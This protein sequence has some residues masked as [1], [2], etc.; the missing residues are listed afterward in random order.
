MSLRSLV[1]APAVLLCTLAVAVPAHAAALPA[2][3]GATDLAAADLEISAVRAAP[4]GDVNG[5]GRSDLAVARDGL[6]IVLGGTGGRLSTSPGLRVWSFTHSGGLQATFGLA[7]DGVGDINGDGLDDVLVRWAVWT[8]TP[9]LTAGY[10]VFGRRDAGGMTTDLAALTSAQGVRIAREGGLSITG[11]EAPGDL[12]GDGREDAAI[13]WR[14]P[15]SGMQGGISVLYGAAA[16]P[17]VIKA[18]DPAVQGY[19]V[20]GAAGEVELDAIGDFD[21]DRRPDL[22]ISR[23]TLYERGGG[24]WIIRGGPRRSGALQ[25]DTLGSAGVPLRWD[26]EV[27][28]GFGSKAGGWGDVDGDGRTEL[29]IGS[30]GVTRV[31]RGRTLTAPI[32]L[33]TA[34]GTQVITSYGYPEPVGDLNG[35]AVPDLA[36]SSANTVLFGRGLGSPF[37][38]PPIFN[39]GA[40][41]LR[42]LDANG[43]QGMGDFNGDGRDDLL[44]VTE[45]RVNGYFGYARGAL[46]APDTT[47]PVVSAITASAPSYVIGP[48]NPGRSMPSLQFSLSELAEVRV[49]RSG[50]EPGGSQRFILPTGT[51]HS[52]TPARPAAQLPGTYTYRLQGYDAAGNRGPIASV[53]V[54]LTWGKWPNC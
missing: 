51:Q 1:A 26:A 5:D 34:T 41:A 48:C 11:A 49:T 47:A 42:L 45:G 39:S 29:V 32:D 38:A 25:I 35:D 54:R 19:S 13:A 21:G 27:P 36:L 20:T 24:A 46:P 50:P 37:S 40:V 44:T 31:V 53:S 7:I 18:T 52:W 22:L 16:F 10:L 43:I 6:S 12:D 3:G 8:D 15:T 30:Y 4:A 17:S 33:A 2:R 9:A 14:S 23:N 28:Y